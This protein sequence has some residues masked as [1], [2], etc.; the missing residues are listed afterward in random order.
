MTMNSLLHSL[1]GFY[2]QIRKGSLSTFTPLLILFS[3]RGKPMTLKQHYQFAPMYNVVMP[4]E[5]LWMTG[6]QMGKSFGIVSSS[7]IKC[8][9]VPFFHTMIVQPRADQIQRLNNTVMRPLLEGSPV[10]KELITST[11]LNKMALK[12]F[13][14]GSLMYMDFCFQSPDR[15]R[16]ASGLANIILD[17]IQDI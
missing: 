3:L 10:R 17:E 2:D 8:S 1:S 6:R 16:G 7:V 15:L 14:T 11:E 4:R 9:V 5:Q 12:Q 13:K